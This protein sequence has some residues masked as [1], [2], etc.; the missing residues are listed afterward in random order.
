MKRASLFSLAVAVILVLASLPMFSQA[1]AWQPNTAFAVNARVTFGGAEF[2]CLQAHTSL[3]GWEPPNVPALW[4]PVNGTPNPTP[5]PTPTPMPTPTPTPSPG[6]CSAAAWSSTQT[7]TGG[8]TASVNGVVY[9]ANFWTLGDDPRTHNGAQGT[10]APWTNVGNC[11]PGPTPTPTPRPTPTPTPQPVGARS[12]RPYIDMSLTVDQQLLAIQQQSGIRIFTLAFIVGNGGC[13]PSWGGIGTVANDMLPNG[14]TILSLVNGVRAAGGDVAISFGGAAGS[15]LALGC[16][17]ASALQAAYQTVIN[18]YHVNKVDFDIEG[19]AAGNT[20][21]VDLRSAALRGLANANPGLQI[22][23]TLPVLPTGLVETGIN[24][25][26]SAVAARTPVSIV[27]IMAMDYGGAFPPNAMGR[28]AID[29]ANST[30]GQMR[31][32]G[33]NANLGITVMIGANDVQPEVLTLADARQ[34]LT[35]AQSTNSGVAL[36]SMWSVARD[37][38]TCANAGFASPVCSG[39]AQG[40]FDFARTFAP[41]R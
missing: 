22:S 13:T 6:N 17:S 14:T 27:N 41:F 25:L 16:G 39:I 26:R 23:L 1:P 20:Q 32:V 7:Y 24:V 18:K 15:E 19:G 40:P 12:F 38:G 4:Q 33:I 36:L 28:N 11:Q 5:T 2:R 35:F 30:L 29:A 31:S 8:M 34:V 9:R 3:V 21:S 10:G 37:N